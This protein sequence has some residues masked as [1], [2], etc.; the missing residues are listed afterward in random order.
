MLL[1]N[2]LSL[3]GVYTKY[4]IRHILASELYMPALSAVPTKYSIRCPLSLLDFPWFRRH[5]SAYC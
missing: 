5:S 3:L 1:A 2:H 4:S